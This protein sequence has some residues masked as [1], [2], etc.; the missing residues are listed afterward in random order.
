MT[1]DTCA[2]AF[3]LKGYLQ[4]VCWI[5][6][7]GFPYSP[8]LLYSQ[9]C[10][11]HPRRSLQ[12]FEKQARLSSGAFDKELTP[13]SNKSLAEALLPSLWKKGKLTLLPPHHN[14][15]TRVLAPASPTRRKSA[16][17]SS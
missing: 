3:V 16:T 7:L 11:Y 14:T 4:V 5:Y 6:I 13:A 10:L 1:L 2:E 8:R 12:R 17:A 15:P 9:Q